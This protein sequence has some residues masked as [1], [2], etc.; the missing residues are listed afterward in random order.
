MLV[1]FKCDR[2]GNEAKIIAKPEKQVLVR[3]QIEDYD[4]VYEDPKYEDGRLKE[5]CFRC[6]KCNNWIFFSFE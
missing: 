4:F 6:K 5:I 2:C 1:T 3:D